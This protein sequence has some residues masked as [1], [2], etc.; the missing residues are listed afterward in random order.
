[1]HYSCAGSQ[2]FA[3]PASFCCASVPIWPDSFAY[4]VTL[5]SAVRAQTPNTEMPETVVYIPKQ[6]NRPLID[7]DTLDIGLTP[8][9]IAR[10][11]RIAPGWRWRLCYK[12]QSIFPAHIPMQRTAITGCSKISK[13]FSNHSASIIIKPVLCRTE[14]ARSHVDCAAVCSQNPKRVR[15]CDSC[16][17]VRSDRHSDWPCCVVGLSVKEV[18]VLHG[19]NVVLGLQ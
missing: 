11:N 19:H 15:R 16:E 18:R 3:P 13:Y 9:S 10:A 12:L 17:C 7:S 8:D 2:I 14:C 6:L 1:M 4:Y 5:R